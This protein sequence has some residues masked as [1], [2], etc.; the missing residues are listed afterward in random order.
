MFMEFD[1]V[2]CNVD[3][4]IVFDCFI[5]DIGVCDGCIV[6]FGYGLL[7]GVCEMDVS[8]LLVLFGGVDGYCYFDQFMFDGMCMVDDF[9]IGMCV[10]ICGG[11]I[12]VILF[13][14]QEKGGL[15]KV[16]V[17]DYYCCVEGCVVVDYGF[18]LIVV[19]FMFYVLKYELLELIC[20]GYILFKVYMIYDDLKLFDCEM[21]DVLNV[22][23]QNNVLVMV[24]V[25]NVDCILWLIEKLVG[26]GC[27]LLC[28]YGLLCLVVVE[29]E[30]MYWVI[31]FVELV[32]VL[33][34]IVYVLGKEVIEQ[35]C[36]V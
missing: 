19:D 12:M 36:W 23:K 27:I 11:M 6:V 34:L 25:E 10:V 29:C 32:D 13:V 33:I 26:E 15:L 24:Y 14:V 31:I 9:F 2:I 21:L 28:F 17:V 1:L 7:C 35:I 30:V 4:V 3:V 20:Q 18:Y 5:C 22:V 8:G 16:V